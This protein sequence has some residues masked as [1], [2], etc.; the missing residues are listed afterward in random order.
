VTDPSDQDRVERLRNIPL[1]QQLSDSTLQEILKCAA[2]FEANTGHVLVQPNQAG[3]GLFII[4]EGSVSVELPDRKRELGPGEFFGELALLRA[5][6]KHTA[7][8]C[9]SSPI[10]ALAIPREEFD[11]LLD[12]EPVIAVEMLKT[13]AKRLAEPG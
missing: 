7:R 6:E 13:L 10:K 2:E 11:K 8:V 5:D 12:R 3:S 9:A 1:L 4:E